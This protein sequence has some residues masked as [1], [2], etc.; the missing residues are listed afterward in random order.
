MQYRRTHKYWRS[1]AK[2]SIDK[3]EPYT[4]A[5]GTSMDT[6][7]KVAGAAALKL[8]DEQI[9]ELG[10]W[11]GETLATVRALIIEAVPD[12]LEEVKWRGTPV[13]SHN[14]GICTGETYKSVVKL[15]FFKGAALKDPT[16]PLNSSLDGNVRRSIDIHEGN[17]TPLILT[18]AHYA[19]SL[20]ARIMVESRKGIA[21]L[22]AYL[23]SKITK[24]LK[25]VSVWPLAKIL[26]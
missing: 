25:M 8:I 12:V 2:N 4:F 14:G 9:V 13:W 18:S 5:K 7:E 23:S 6:Q 26:I 10:D 19:S 17:K 22:C 3:P 24:L 11:R 21:K 15:T 16:K 1:K 20:L